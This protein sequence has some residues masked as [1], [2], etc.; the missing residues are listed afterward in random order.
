MSEEGSFDIF[1]GR[2]G[3]HWDWVN[4]EV[5]SRDF[6]W[7]DDDTS[8]FDEW[9]VT[10]IW[11]ESH[12]M[13]TFWAFW[14]GDFMNIAS[15]LDQNPIL[16]YEH[17]SPDLQVAEWMLPHLE[18]YPEFAA[19]I[20][21]STT[22][23]GRAEEAILREWAVTFP[24]LVMAE[25]EEEFYRLYEAWLETTINLGIEIVWEARNDIVQE[26]RRKLGMD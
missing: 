1:F 7:S 26:N 10:D 19:I 14:N 25:S 4:G 11:G 17:W 5:H 16:I 6:F 21:D 12:L 8:A 9:G 22:D 18:L 15:N 24:R 3:M 2:E 13:G 20:L 23:A